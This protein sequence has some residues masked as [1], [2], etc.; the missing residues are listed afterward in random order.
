M[1]GLERSVGPLPL[2]CLL[3]VDNVCDGKLELDSTLNELT[4]PNTVLLDVRNTL[5]IVKA[6]QVGTLKR[7]VPISPSEALRVLANVGLGDC[8]QAADQSGNRR[9]ANL[10][11]PRGR[12][13]ATGPAFGFP[14]SRVSFDCP[15]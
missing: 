7:S 14:T 1:A 15:H 10:P 9:P 13:E 11:A 6:C 12:P 3:S 5:E 2:S 8:F 4:V